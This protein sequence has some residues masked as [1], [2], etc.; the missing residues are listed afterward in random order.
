MKIRRQEKGIITLA[1]IF[2]IGLLALSMALATALSVITE[3]KKNRN[4]VFGDRSFLAAESAAREGVYQYINDTSYLAGPLNDAQ[5]LNNSSD[6]SIYIDDDPLNWPY[7]EVKG[8]AENKSTYRNVAYTLNIFP[9]GLAFDHAVY[10]ENNLSFGGNATVNGSIFAE[11]NIDFI[12][13][14]AE[15]N[16]NAYSP[17]PIPDT[18]NI[19]GDAHPGSSS[20]PPP[21]IDPIPYRIEAINNSTFFINTEDAEDCLNN[22]IQTAVVYVEST[23]KTKIQGNN[24]NLT[25]SLVTE[26]NLDIT[27]G[28]FTATDDHLAI[29]VQGNL[30][31]A[32]GA[33]VYGIVYVTGTTSFGGGTNTIN[34]SLI[35]VGGTNICDITGNTTVNFDPIVME[36][37][38]DIEGLD[39]VSAGPPQITGWHEE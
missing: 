29:F 23:E 15:I 18:D 37:W 26:G 21:Q 16:G 7:V 28:T 22:K 9:E 27:G 38:E 4:V 2:S 13:S 11:N 6:G 20:I 35:S 30:K 8:S 17:N 5:L 19:N 24:T 36:N 33:T 32:G 1:V 39:T 14:S 10:S 3:L 12:G 25:G 31:I 34:G